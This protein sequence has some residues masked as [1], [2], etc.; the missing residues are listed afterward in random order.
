VTAPAEKGGGRRRGASTLADLC[1]APRRY[2]FDAAVRVLLHA[3][4]TDDPAEAVR[5]R[6]PPG[7]AFP[8][9]DITT[10][11]DA[12]GR[13]PQVTTTVMG[14]TGPS[15]VLPRAYTEA[16]GMSPRNRTR[17]MH[18]FFDLLAHRLVAGFAQ[19]GAKYRLPRAADAA[20]LVGGGTLD[21][22]SGAVLALTGY[23]TPHLAERL[24]AGAT[25]LLH[26]AGLFATRPRSAERLAALLS[27]W[28]GRRVEVVQF[29][30]AWLNLPP[31]QRS[32][33]PARGREGRFNR[34]GVDAAI[35]IRAWDVQAR[36]V[37]RLGPLDAAAFTALLPDGP[38]YRRL[39]SLVQ[40]FLGL[41]TGFAINPVLAAA[42]VGPLRLQAEQPGGAR[43]GWTTWLPAPGLGRRGDATEALFEVELASAAG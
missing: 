22:V 15:G 38:A 41:E 11:D 25:P 40:A 3:R 4:R 9:A 28:L 27:D 30:G 36:I 14:L 20:R 23:G 33:L 29:A 35:G 8:E 26:Y 37:L 18:D 21:P 12:A 1:A 24:P 43:L 31:D 39:V 2:R 17:A 5:F 32:C 10:V 34:L 6:S 42:E 19:A 13:V 16:V 7:F